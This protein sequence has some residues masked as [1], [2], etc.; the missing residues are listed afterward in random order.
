M[1]ESGDRNQWLLKP[2]GPDEYTVF[3]SVGDSAEVPPKIHAALEQL[4]QAVEEAD[5]AFTQEGACHL[6]RCGGYC[7]GKCSS[8]CN[9]YGHCSLLMFV[10]PEEDAATGA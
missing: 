7:D 1:T 2:V 6:G 3:V 9:G 4:L 10:A 8:K 5:A